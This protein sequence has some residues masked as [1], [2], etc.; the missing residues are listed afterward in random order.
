MKDDDVLQKLAE[1]RHRRPIPGGTSLSPPAATFSGDRRLNP[2]KPG[3]GLGGG[4]K[5]TRTW[6]SIGD[7]AADLDPMQAVAD[8]D[9]ACV[10]RGE[11][12]EAPRGGGAI[13]TRRPR[14]RAEIATP[15]TIWAGA[16]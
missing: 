1:G 11:L 14:A 3:G 12:D 5:G 10:G 13:W 9:G 7:G 2:V 4:T 8:S 6:R 15:A 16:I